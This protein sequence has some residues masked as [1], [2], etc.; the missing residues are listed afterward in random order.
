MNLLHPIQM[1]F[2]SG[3]VCM[4]TLLYHSAVA[5]PDAAAGQKLFEARCASCHSVARQATGPALKNVDQRHS[6]EWIIRFVHSSQTVIKSGDT[7]A[8]R[9]FTQFNQTVMPD[10]PDLTEGDI[11][12]IIAFIKEESTK[13]AAA[14]ARPAVSE[15]ARAYR[16]KSG[17][18]HQLV[19][20]DTEGDHQPLQF[21]LAF[22]LIGFAGLAIMLGVLLLAVRVN[23]VVVRQYEK[24]I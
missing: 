17:F 3:V 13:L 18:L 7:S 5:R 19:Y 6:E 21:N 14:P 9:L 22:A 1:F 16:G 2:R 4:L 23:D 8:N 20:L 24:D 15:H 11:R 10:H 12:G